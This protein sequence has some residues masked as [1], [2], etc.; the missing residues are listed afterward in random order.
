MANIHNSDIDC[1][2]F[3]DSVL[4]F[5]TFLKTDT[6]RQCTISAVC[7][8]GQLNKERKN[9]CLCVANHQK[10]EQYD[11]NWWSPCDSRPDSFINELHPA[12]CERGDAGHV[13]RSRGA[14][15]LRQALSNA[16]CSLFSY[17]DGQ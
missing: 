17:R 6:T 15:C 2:H 14:S 12:T 10:H 4:Y 3:S 1:S 16:E 8:G 5:F 9:D 11:E 13:T 7:H